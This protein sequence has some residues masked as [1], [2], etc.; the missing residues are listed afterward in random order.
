MA[1]ENSK[2]RDQSEA[3]LVA[4]SHEFC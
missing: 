3:S 1:V 4:S 2:L